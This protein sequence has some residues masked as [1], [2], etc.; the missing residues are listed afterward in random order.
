MYMQ[1]ERKVICMQSR[2]PKAFALSALLA[3]SMATSPALAVAAEM[4]M[5][6][7]GL[8]SATSNAVTKTEGTQKQPDA[9]TAPTQSEPTSVADENLAVD[10]PLADRPNSR[11]RPTP[12]TS[13][14]K[15]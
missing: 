4:P 11:H 9:K 3:L 8:P 1:P 10:E 14:P 15:A 13:T 5:D 12:S 7:A 6:E 2:G